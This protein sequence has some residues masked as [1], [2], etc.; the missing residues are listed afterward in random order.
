[1]QFLII[2]G[3]FGSPQENWFPWLKTELQSLGQTVFVPRFPIDN[4]DALLSFGLNAKPKQQ[5]LKNWLETFS[6]TI[7]NINP[8]E[9]LCIISH[10]IGPVFTLHA[11]STYKIQLDSAIFVSPFLSDPLIPKKYLPFHIVNPGFYKEDFNFHNLKKLIPISYVLYGSDDPYVDTKY[12]IEFANKMGSQI[13]E[14]IGGGHL[15]SAYPKFPLVL[16]L[17]KTRIN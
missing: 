7:E 17:C 4:Y 6:K 10:S 16:E 12:P 8:K 9:E 5:T 15:G 3:S 14:V 13:I 2:H 11:V 1:M